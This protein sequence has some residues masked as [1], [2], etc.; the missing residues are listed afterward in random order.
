MFSFEDI[1]TLKKDSVVYECSYLM[2]NVKVTLITDPAVSVTEINGEEK[3]QVRFSALIELMTGT[4]RVGKS[5][6]QNYLVTEGLEHYG[7]SLYN[8]PVYISRKELQEGPDIG[9]KVTDKEGNE[10]KGEL[11]CK[12]YPIKE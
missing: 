3:R 8:M 9:F 12:Q 2:G 4:G 5:N 1:L 7:P 10:V 6:E 11:E